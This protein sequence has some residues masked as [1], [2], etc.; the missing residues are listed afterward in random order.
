DLWIADKDCETKYCPTERFNSAESSTFKNLNQEFSII[1]GTAYAIGN[2]G[3]DTVSFNKI[4]VKNQQFAIVNKTR[5]ALDNTPSLGKDG[6]KPDGILGLGYPGLTTVPKGAKTYNPFLFNMIEQGVISKPIFSYYMGSMS[7]AGWT[8]ELTLGGTNQKKYTGD[9]DY[10][11]VTSN[12][13]P[14]ELWQINAQGWSLNNKNESVII[15][16]PLEDKVRTAVIDT[17]TTLSYMDLDY[18]VKLL[19]TITGQTTLDM[20]S[21]T[22]IFHIDCKYASSDKYLTMAFSHHSNKVDKKP[23][24]VE[25]PVSS[26]VVPLDTIDISTAKKCGWGIIGNKSGQDFLIGQNMLRHTYLVFDMECH[27]IGFAALVD[28]A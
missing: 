2:F 6:V 10:V 21:Q 9:I 19:T 14:L 18:T 3:T 5:G 27:K 20:E 26:L 23:L 12:K 8:G 7:A 15:H 28:T 24:V 22:G 13:K 4:A 25:I 11:P 17:G 1:Y 16:N